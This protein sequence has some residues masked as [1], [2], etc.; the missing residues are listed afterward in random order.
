MARRVAITS[1]NS[2]ALRR[3]KEAM[4]EELARTE[5]KER[6]FTDAFDAIVRRQKLDDQLG[7]A[8]YTLIKLNV[9]R[10]TLAAELQLPTKEIQRLIVEHQKALAAEQDKSSVPDDEAKVK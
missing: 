1:K 3:A 2:E 4:A 5:E 8:L 6:A 7:A 9:S 10:K